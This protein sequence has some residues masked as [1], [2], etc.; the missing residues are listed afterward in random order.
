MVV[1]VGVWGG[2]GGG[3]GGKCFGGG[4][5]GWCGASDVMLGGAG[6]VCALPSPLHTN[7]HKMFLQIDQSG[8]PKPSTLNCFSHGG[9]R[10]MTSWLSFAGFGVH[11]SHS[12]NSLYPPW[13]TALGV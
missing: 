5:G 2:G 11:E 9:S 7:H 10:G 13:I 3:G 1:L 4:G 6:V 12:R 8:R